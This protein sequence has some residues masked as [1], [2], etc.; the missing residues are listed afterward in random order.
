MI[1]FAY[2][3]A[4]NASTG[5]TPFKLTCSF[6]PQTSYKEDV[7]PRSLLK[8]TDKLAIK[9]RELMI[10]CRKNLQHAQELHKWY[11]DKHAKPRSYIPGNKVCLNNKYN[12][13]KWNWKLEAQFFR[14]FRVLHLLGK[15]A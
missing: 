9:L 13:T 15:Q 6:H 4:K 5:H 10:V 3:N 8:S 11:H 12:E 7:D 1:E 2:N 14:I